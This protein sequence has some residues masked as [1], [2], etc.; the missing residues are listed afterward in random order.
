MKKWWILPLLGLMLSLQ[1]CVSKKKFSEL[2]EQFFTAKDRLNNLEEENDSLRNVIL[3]NRVKLT[4]TE[5]E[6]AACKKDYANLQK[7]FASTETAYKNLQASY[8][9][10]AK[11]STAALKAQSIKTRDLIRKLEQKEQKLNEE[12]RKLEQL[13]R[14]LDERSKRIGELEQILAKK[15][16][17]LQTVKRSLTASLDEFK[18]Q[19][20]QV[21][22][23]DGQLYVSMQNKLLFDSGS[24]KL[25][26]QGISAIKKLSQVL[27]ANP[28]IEITIEGHTDNVPYHGNAYIRDNWDLSVKRATTVVRE[29]LKNDAIDP[30]RL[31]AAGRS[32]YHPVA[33]NTTPEGRA[34]NRRIEVILIPNMAK[35]KALLDQEKAQEKPAEKSGDNS[36]GKPKP[37]Q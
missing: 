16:S 21:H 9:A 11:K 25:K 36:I 19:G 8:D 7:L 24:W 35:L 23:K 2:E 22:M 29:L 6:L 32:K 33:P 27:A 15:D 28:D 31:M 18:Q 3:L 17:I 10:L 30:K 26:G 1:N 20:L 4:K 14:Q 34:K 13:K 37:A 12:Q 5:N